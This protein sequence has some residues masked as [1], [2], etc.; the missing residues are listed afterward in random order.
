MY[1]YERE[2]MNTV[3]LNLSRPYN[4]NNLAVG[5]KQSRVAFKGVIGDSLLK[6]VIVTRTVPTTETFLSKIKGTFGISSDKAK[7]VL[8]SF[9]KLTGELLSTKSIQDATLSDLTTQHNITLNEIN[10]LRGKLQYANGMELRQKDIIEHQ[11]E[12]IKEQN[13]KIKELEKYES[14]AKVK[15][16][17]EIGVVMPEQMLTTIEEMKNLNQE[18]KN[19]LFKYVMTGKDQEKF[20]QY[21]EQNNIILKGFKDGMYNI[22]DVKTAIDKAR[23]SVCLGYDN[24]VVAYRMLENALKFQPEGVYI[25]SPAIYQ[26][27]KTNAESLITPM[28]DTNR[29]SHIDIDTTLKNV[30]EYHSNLD[31]SMQEAS[32]KG[33]KYLSETRKDFSTSQSYRSFQDIEGNIHDISLDSLAAG[34]FGMARVKT[35]DGK[36]LYNHSGLVD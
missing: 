13:V 32:K 9:V 11:A 33:L 36:M 6:D 25:N 2:F 34:Y 5:S 29:Y 16:I 24:D 12:E 26:Q 28:K 3:N 35:Q 7:D 22:S 17:D 19:S 18:A 21:M 23:A 4:N 31:K 10:D 20:L 15:S 8:D 14:M 1:Y 30:I 27:V